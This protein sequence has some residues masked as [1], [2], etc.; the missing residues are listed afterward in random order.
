M[1]HKKKKWKAKAVMITRCAFKQERIFSRRDC[2]VE[3]ERCSGV[4]RQSTEVDHYVI[5]CYGIPLTIKNMFFREQCGCGLVQRIGM[6][7]QN[8][9]SPWF[10]FHIG[11]KLACEFSFLKA[12]AQL[13][14]ESSLSQSCFVVFVTDTT[15]FYTMY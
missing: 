8:G 3:G 14:I 7:P 5:A 11:T 1:G 15:I 2:V 9:S 6:F 13:I 12:H 10:Y 4:E